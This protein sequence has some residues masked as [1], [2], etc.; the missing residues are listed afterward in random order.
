MANQ[1]TMVQDSHF[2][3]Y[4][5]TSDEAVQRALIWFEAIRTFFQQAGLGI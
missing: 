4:S 2:E 5:P 3:V 1:W